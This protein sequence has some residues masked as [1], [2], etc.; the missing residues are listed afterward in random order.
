MWCGRVGLC[1]AHD[2]CSHIRRQNYCT[3]K[4]WIFYNFLSSKTKLFFLR[5]IFVFPWRYFFITS[6]SLLFTLG[7]FSIIK[8]SF[9][10][11]PDVKIEQTFEIFNFHRVQLQIV[12]Q[13]ELQLTK[14]KDRLTAMMRHL[15]LELNK[16]GE[17]VR[18]I[19]FIIRFQISQDSRILV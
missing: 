18:I 3:N 6:Q 14:E 9:F 13:L 11:Q 15:K 7:F 1:K 5:I 2:L 16:T 17:L 10:F 4:V 12:N 8:K 19:L